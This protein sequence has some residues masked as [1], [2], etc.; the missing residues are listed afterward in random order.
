MPSKTKQICR[1]SRHS[2][3]NCFGDLAPDDHISLL[4]AIEPHFMS[5]FSL[6]ALQKNAWNG[7]LFLACGVVPGTSFFDRDKVGDFKCLVFAKPCPHFISCIRPSSTN[8]FPI[9]GR[10]RLRGGFGN[11]LFVGERSLGG[12]PRRS[13]HSSV[14]RSIA[15]VDSPCAAILRISL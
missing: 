4:E 9:S 10:P 6:M 7:L 13:T 11:S 5:R 14:S 1:S 15:A 12:A 2:G 3:V 8:N